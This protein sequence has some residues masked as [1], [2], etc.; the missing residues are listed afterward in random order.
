M[1]DLA[2]SAAVLIAGVVIWFR[3]D[4]H[5]IDP[6]CTLGF[7]ILVLFS[8]LGV[9]RSAISVLLE[10]TP[11]GISWQHVHDAISNT[12]YVTDV[13]DLHIWS[14]S[15]GQPALSVHC[16]SSDPESLSN[17]NQVCIRFGIAD[18]TIQIQP[19]A[20]LCVTCNSLEC[21]AI[22]DSA[23]EAPIRAKSS[24]RSSCECPVAATMEPRNTKIVC[25]KIDQY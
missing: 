24:S 21:V 19:T 15:H 6:I 25:A 7:S 12:P 2:Q 11:P 9:L 17:I 14:I 5:A 13:H 3:P 18:T 4:W 10:E 22:L 20:G 8:T 1:A 23:P 16:T